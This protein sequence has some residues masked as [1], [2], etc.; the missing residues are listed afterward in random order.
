MWSVRVP[1]W[2]HQLDFEP[3][4][5]HVLGV[6]CLATTALA[7]ASAPIA[8][9]EAEGTV[10]GR[11]SIVLSVQNDELAVGE[12]NTLQVFISNSGDVDRGGPSV[13]VDRVTTARNLRLSV[14]EELLPDGLARAIDVRTGTVVVGSVPPGVAGPFEFDLDVSE[15]LEPGTYEIPVRVSYDYT[16][17]VDYGPGRSP[18]YGDA[19]QSVIRPVGVT[20]DDRPRFEVTPVPGQSLA[21]GE[22]DTLRLAVSNVGTEPA[23]DVVVRLSAAE[24]AITFGRTDRPQD[25]VRPIVPRIGAGETGYV[26]VPVGTSRDTPP[27][28]YSLA[29]TIA[30]EDASGIA[31][32]TTPGDVAVTVSERRR[33]D[34][35]NLTGSLRVDWT[36]T[37]SGRLVNTG[38]TTVSN[39]TLVF[40][41]GGDGLAARAGEYALGDLSPNESV[42]FEFLVDVSN[43]TAAG[44]RSVAFHVRYRDRSGDRQVSRELEGRL[45]VGP[46]RDPFRVR[47][48][49][50]TVPVDGDAVLVVEVTNA[51]DE[52]LEDVRGLL[53]AAPPFETEDASAFAGRLA[54]G[55]SARLRYDLETDSDAI[56]KNDSVDVAVAYTDSRGEPRVTDPAVVPVTI[57]ERSGA[58]PVVP[59]AAAL[60]AV[61]VA[62]VWW[63]RRG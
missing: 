41:P 43:R 13:H 23:T 8:A 20:V 57:V 4:W 34:V 47:P 60:L 52:P 59:A 56:P 51:V 50:A 61:V 6:A 38:E 25:V 33:F 31:R 16:S 40:R 15:A 5:W 1:Q 17:F 28:T 58:V 42:P 48:V 18:R 22:N 3:S 12:R 54:P 53:T 36:G 44:P 14:A 26:E 39:A 55:E 7:V 62:A 35:R 63:W 46:E 32:E 45:V 11:P 37:V 29:A 2:C 19:S 21:A 49:E 24:S 30:Y 9:Q 27:G 10:V